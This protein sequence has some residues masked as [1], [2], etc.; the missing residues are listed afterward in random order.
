MDAA[1]G[2]AAPVLRY[3]CSQAHCEEGKED[4]EVTMKEYNCELVRK[5][6]ELERKQEEVKEDTGTLNE[7]QGAELQQKTANE[8][9]GLKRERE[10][11]KLD[12]NDQGVADST[13]TA[14]NPGPVK[15]SAE[16]P[17]RLKAASSLKGMKEGRDGKV[18]AA[19]AETTNTAGASGVK[20]GGVSFDSTHSND[21]TAVL[22]SHPG[23]S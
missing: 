12:S 16:Q 23:C 5:E 17:Q 10:N 18:D 8:E 14:A 15:T 11:D 21:A 4:H 22:C 1:S 7:Q 6:S 19:T 9:E 13:T 3:F 20:Q 2:S